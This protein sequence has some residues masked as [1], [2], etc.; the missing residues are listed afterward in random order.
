MITIR[1]SAILDDN[2]KKIIF[3]VQPF[4]VGLDMEVT[5]GHDTPRGQLQTIAKYAK[6]NGV[7]FPEF[8]PEIEDI[9]AIVD[10]PTVGRVKTWERTWGK[11]LNIGVIINPPQTGT[12][13]FP[14][15]RPSG[16]QMLGKTIDPSP[17]I[18]PL[19]DPNP[20]PID[21]SIKVNGVANIVLAQ[22]ILNKA[23]EA[24]AGIRKIVPES[25]NGC[26]HTDTN[27]SSR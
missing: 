17:H 15:V 25:R 1:E 4:T 14:Y 19:N 11:L 8:D 26:I 2:Q 23:K 22:K 13:Y 24:G 27:I 16:E 18:K 12:C 21:W 6:Q 9:G 7:Y 3:N 20:C 5:R 10:I